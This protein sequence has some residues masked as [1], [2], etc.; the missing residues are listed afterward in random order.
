MRTIP[1]MVVLSPSDDIEARAAVKASYLHNGPVYLRFGRMATPIINDFPGY[2]FEIGKGVVLKEGSDISL[3]ATGL[4]VSEAIS[5]AE[6]L[7]Q[8]G[9]SAEVINIHT[10]K[11]L[12]TELI[13][14]TAQKTGNVLTIEEHS[15]IG[16]LGEA[17]CSTLA[18]YKVAKVERIGINDEFGHS[19]SAEA[20]LKQFGLCSSNIVQKAKGLLK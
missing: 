10:I 18:G 16:G 8:E 19:G 13:L 14:K 3:V 11:P 7:A 9:I 12:D 2:K 1:G 5:A 6:E 20:L 15:V 17:V 4:M